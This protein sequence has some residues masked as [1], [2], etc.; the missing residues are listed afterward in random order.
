MMRKRILSSKISNL[1]K[2]VLIL[3][4]RQ[5]GKS[6]LLAGLAPE[7]IIDLAQENEFLRYASDIDLFTQ[8]VEA[9]SATTIFVD[10]IQR[11]PGLLNSV[12]ALLDQ[13]KRRKQVLRFLLSGSSAR[14]LKRGQ[15]NLLPGRIFTYQLGGLCA[16]EL[17]YR[18]DTS[19]A[20]RFGFLPEPFLEPRPELSQKL[21]QSYAATYLK[22]EIQAEA[23]SRNIQGFARFLVSLAATAGQI[24]DFSKI[25]TK[26]KVSRSSCVR[27]VEILEDTLIANRV[28]VFEG[29]KADIVQHPKL[30][31]FDVGVLNGLLQNFVDSSDRRGILFEHL[32]YSQLRNS[33]MAHDLPMD[34]QYFRT[35]H[36]VEVDFVVT[37][38]QKVWAIEVKTGD[39]SSG[40]LSG[41]RSFREYFPDVHRCV[42][43]TP[44]EKKRAVDD[45]LVCDWITLLQ[46]MGL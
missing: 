10:E 27:F 32:I 43:V 3:G 6:T 17:D 7:L 40:D 28:S 44:R 9:S 8:Q 19:Q 33:A 24:L 2:S 1:E 42:V 29:T 45:I 4:P 21:L 18:V 20:L 30:Y 16:A 22:E 11:I 41:L 15:A 34:I 36:G 46:E 5:T 35:R 37:L 14:K 13:A 23:L 31:F 26:A 38:N 12:Q 39:A 25:S